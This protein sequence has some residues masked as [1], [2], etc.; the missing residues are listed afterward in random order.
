MTILLFLLMAAAITLFIVK[1][2]KPSAYWMALVLLGWFLSMSGLILFIAKYGGFYYRV[3]IV[4]FFNDYIRNLLLHSPFSLETISRMITVG[5]SMFIYSLLG[6][7]VSLFYYRPFRQTWKLHAL[8]AIL[9]LCNIL[10]YD[11]HLYKQALG[12]L[13]RESTYVIGWLTRGW[14][15]GSALVAIALM[16]WRY[17]RS[18][19]PWSKKQIQHILYGVFALVLFYFYLGFMGPLQVTDV[20][21]YYVLYSDFSNFNPPLTLF[22][23]YLSIIV[24][25]IFSAISIISIWRYTEIEKQLGRTDLQLER[26]LK[27]ANMGARVFTHGIKNQLLMVQLL[28]DQSIK[29]KAPDHPEAAN[30][31]LHKASEIVSHTMKRLDQLYNSFK[32]THLQLKPIPVEELLNKLQERIQAVPDHVQLTIEPPKEPILI[33]ADE[34]HLVEA[35][36]NIISNAMEA[37][38][39]ERVGRV[40]VSAYVEEEWVILTIADNGVGIAK[41]QLETIFDPFFTSKNTTKN[42]GVGLSYANYIVGGHYGRI[43]VESTPGEGSMF[44]VIA[45]V[46]FIQ[47]PGA[48]KEG[49]R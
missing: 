5:R 25:G 18:T 11:P 41:D 47:S 21:T 7:S 40:G 4:L 28:I 14:L 32:T 3:N 38:P 30:Q 43:H 13:S 15:I 23:W 19:V 26:K 44:Q 17:K 49:N 27:T 9:P 8:N 24:T 36:Y 12:V 42:W 31:K 34:A 48:E 20:R 1:A 29:A 10:F 33:L 16:I 46:Y 2:N 35:L 22:E 6:L 37:I 45:P 39:E